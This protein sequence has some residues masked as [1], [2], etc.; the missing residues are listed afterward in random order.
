MP[1]SRPLGEAPA[2]ADQV[3]ETPR[4]GGAVRAPRTRWTAMDLSLIAVFAA[5][6]A[7][8][9]AVPG[10]NIGPLGV[11]IT[12]QTLAV[13]LTGMVLGA[14]R[15]FSAISLYVLVGLAGLP[16]FAGVSK[17]TLRQKGFSR[18]GAAGDTHDLLEQS[19]RCRDSVL[20]G[21]DGRYAPSPLPPVLLGDSARFSTGYS[22]AQNCRNPME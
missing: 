7:A 3:P 2:A 13:S 15:G 21:E 11:P 18:G 6:M 12:L 9:I 8:S 14:W 4:K 22:Y 5:L 16:V 19:C 20:C 10:V 17:T 1:A